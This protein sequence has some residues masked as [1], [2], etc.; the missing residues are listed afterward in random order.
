MM[1]KHIFTK[2]KKLK[3]WEF[4]ISLKVIILFYQSKSIELHNWL[5]SKLLSLIN[6]DDYSH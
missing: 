1:N 6:L 2:K 4:N 3:S 5:I